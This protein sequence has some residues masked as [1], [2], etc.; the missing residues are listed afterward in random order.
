MNLNSPV[1]L[2][3]C[4]FFQGA[5]AA[6]NAADA[7]RSDPAAAARVRYHQSR[8]ADLWDIAAAKDAQDSKWE[9]EWDRQI[10]TH[11]FSWRL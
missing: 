7:L 11:R 3:V 8:L 2:R 1:L 4:F 6:L 9:G 10:Q 5:G